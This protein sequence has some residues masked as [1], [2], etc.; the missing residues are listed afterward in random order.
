MSTPSLADQQREKRTSA[1]SKLALGGTAGADK[2]RC[3]RSSGW[4]PTEQTNRLSENA[5]WGQRRTT[6]A[7][8]IHF[9]EKVILLL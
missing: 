7:T 4:H 5:L 3:K 2:S 8:S 9:N 1:T 6:L